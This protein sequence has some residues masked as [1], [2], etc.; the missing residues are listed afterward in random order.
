MSAWRQNRP[1]T[2]V[3]VLV[4]A[5]FVS[6]ALAFVVD[7]FT[8]ALL[9]LLVTSTFDV[10]TRFFKLRELGFTLRY[11]RI[12]VRAILIAGGCLYFPVLWSVMGRS[13]GQALF[14]LR[15]VS[16][17]GER[18]SFV[19]SALRA[20]G[21]WVSAL[22]LLAGFLWAIIDP[23]HEAWHDKLTRTRVVYDPEPHA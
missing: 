7:L 16:D 12:G 14:G 15:V 19:R 10:L 5:G 3:T 1:G 2:S 21:L 22:P 23:A 4:P 18:L 20:A 8:L 6:R 13:L 9:G 11:A 17:R